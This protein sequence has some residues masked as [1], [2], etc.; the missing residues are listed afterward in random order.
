M[1][2]IIEALIGCTILTGVFVVA[3]IILRITALVR[4]YQQREYREEFHKTWK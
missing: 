1:I 4:K 2:R 3:V